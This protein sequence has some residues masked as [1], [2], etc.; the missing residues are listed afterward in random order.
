MNQTQRPG[1]MFEPDKEDY[2]SEENEEPEPICVE[3]NWPSIPST[4]ASDLTWCSCTNCRVMPTAPENVCCSSTQPL[5]AKLRHHRC[6][7]NTQSFPKMCLDFE[8]LE[9]LFSGLC[10]VVAEEV[11]HQFNNR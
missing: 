6:I 11:P 2:L 4:N 9:M 10:D 5:K 3:K 7:C 1:F 8:V